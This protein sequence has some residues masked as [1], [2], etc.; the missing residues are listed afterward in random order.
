MIFSNSDNL[1]WCES[2]RKSIRG[3]LM[4][5]ITYLIMGF[6]F[7]FVSTFAF[8]SGGEGEAFSPPVVSVIPFF[9]I[10]MVIATFPLIPKIDH[11]WENNLNRAI[12]SAV[13]GIPMIIYIWMNQP[14]Q[15]VHTAIEYVQFLSLLAALFITAGGIHIG[16]SMI[17][18]PKN[19]SIILLIGYVIASI[20]GTTG[21]AMILIYPI[22]RA[23]KP[24]KYVM[25]TI[26]FFIFIV[27]NTGGLLSP[28][29][30]PPLFLG[31]LRGID[32]FWFLKLFPLWVVNGIFIFIIYYLLDAYY[33]K[34]ED[35]EKVM[36]NGE[37]AEPIHAVGLINSIFLLGVIVS[38]AAA[39]PTPYREI[40]MYIMIACSLYYWK[41]SDVAKKGREL[42]EFTFHAIIEVAVVFAGIFATMMPCLMYLGLHG[43]ELGV[44]SPLKFFYLTGIF[45]S[46]LD[47]A[48]TFLV[49]LEL[50]L[51]VEGLSKAAEMM[52]GE[53]AII[54]GAISAG[55]VF[56]GANTYIGNA[57]N[58]MVRAI[59][60]EK[61]IK[62]P[63]F[64]GFMVWSVIILIPIFSFVAWLFFVKLPFPLY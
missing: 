60:E 59:A 19:N 12:V 24:R 34:K 17:P 56:M 28:I 21:A 22:I 26:I 2:M 10:L 32:F 1:T 57:P 41:K 51:S 54:L 36:R 31:F 14:S 38:V 5:K 48:P 49:F 4:N 62:M 42:N 63:S 46:F 58:F 29:G 55:A 25:H 37:A 18:S 15:V 61:G 7:Q 23:N 44:D 9:L 33:F 27:C 64:F 20:V 30:D 39:V 40:I 47:N 13:L 43:S 16:G 11:W 6:I 35:Q 52:T 8:A 3:M 45:S 50:G 53:A